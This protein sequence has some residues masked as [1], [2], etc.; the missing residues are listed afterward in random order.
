MASASAYAL[1]T[2]CGLERSMHIALV[3]RDLGGGGTQ[4]SVLWLARGLL[5]RGH[6]VDIV[7]FRAKIHFPKEVPHDARLFVVENKP[8]RLTEECAA[9]ELARLIRLHASSRSS[10]WIDMA[11]ALHWD[12]WCVPS[13]RLARWSRAVASYMKIEGPDCVLPNLS[14]AEAATLLAVR[15]SV[16]HPP[17]V[18]IIHAVVRRDRSWRLRRRSWRLRRHL[19]P[20]AAHIVSVSQGVAHSVVETLGVPREKITTI[21]N[22][23]ATP[24]LRSK[25]AELPDHP[26]FFDDG[27]PLV[28]SAGRL[29]KQKN[30]STLI[31]AFSLVAARRPCRLIVIG[32]GRE[33]RRLERLVR[34]L[35]LVDLVSLPGWV[36]NPFAF[37]SHASLFVLSSISEGFGMVIV[38]ALACGCPCISTDYP[39]GPAEILRN[40]ELGPLVPV[41]DETAL[42]EAMYQVLDWPPDRRVLQE[43]AADFTV[44]MAAQRYEELLLGLIAST[45]DERTGNDQRD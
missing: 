25:M 38:E 1:S 23:V 9:P 13:K 2:V 31:R 18:P 27:A 15:S 3:V 43:R 22:P 35:R 7:L 12:L 4:R 40:G 44:E 39:A 28:L 32:E 8:D 24:H 10:H 26:W 17:V 11:A 19:F 41:G 34:D 30:F 37:M 14:R 5:D 20:H 6:Q 16:R 42:A 29:S 21:Y 33:R 45:G 36:D